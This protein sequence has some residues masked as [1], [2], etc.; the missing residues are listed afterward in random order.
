MNAKRKRVSPV[1]VP[2]LALP[3]EGDR[4][5]KTCWPENH[6][7]KL[8]ALLPFV[9]RVLVVGWRGSDTHITELIATRIGPLEFAH[10]VSLGEAGAIETSLAL[11]AWWGQ[12]TAVH[13]YD[14]GFRAY[15]ESDALS[16][17]AF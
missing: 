1:G 17:L 16:A 7:A 15:T 11:S 8:E 5:G 4:E 12:S 6:L 2:A 10:I 9:D 3:M 13:R 14:G